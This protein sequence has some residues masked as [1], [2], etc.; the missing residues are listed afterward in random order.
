MKD[1]TGPAFSVPPREKLLASLEL[2]PS[3][4]DLESIKPK[5]LE[6]RGVG[7]Q[8]TSQPLAGQGFTSRPP[9][10]YARPVRGGLQHLFD[11]AASRFGTAS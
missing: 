8:A 3:E 1:E 2:P 4:C 10:P 9:P 7:A 11:F 6:G 5:G